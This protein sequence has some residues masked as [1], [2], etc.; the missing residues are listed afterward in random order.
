[1]TAIK[2]IGSNP[3]VGAEQVQAMPGTADRTLVFEYLS[4][5]VLGPYD[6][7]T[8]LVHDQ[9]FRR[10]LMGTLYPA[11]AATEEVLQNE[12]EEASGGS[13]GEE[14]ADDPVTMANSW[15]PS[16][17]GLSFYVG[18]A[19][20]IECKVWGARY[21]SER[22]GRREAFRR[23]PIASMEEPESITLLKPGEEDGGRRT[24]ADVFGG[25]A[26][27]D[28]FWRPLETGHLVTV[29]LRNTQE[30][31]DPAVVDAAK[32]LHQVGLECRPI[33]GV[34]REYP[35]VEFLSP[36]KEEQELR[37]LHRR[38]RVFAI[39]HG[40]AA[41][42][43]ASG[44][45][46]TAVRT[47]LL[48]RHEVPAVTAGGIKDDV[49]L[50]IAYLSDSSVQTDHLLQSLRDFCSHYGAWIEQLPGA[51]ADIPKALSGAR[52]RLVKRLD[53]ALAR[54]RRGVDTLERNP[55]ALRA[56]RLANRAMLMQM[57]HASDAAAGSRRSREAA[58]SA[59]P[60]YLSL[61]YKWRPFQLAFMLLTL[62]SVV[63]RDDTERDT[64]DLLW[65]PT[66]GGKTEAYLAIAALQI[67]MRRL[68]PDKKLDGA[69]TTVITRYTL[70]LLTTQQFQRAATLICACE[71]IRRQFDDE[72]GKIPISIGLW[73]GDTVVPNKYAKAS[74]QFSNLLEDAN[75]ICPFQLE[76]CPWCG[77]EMVPQ[78]RDEDIGAY[79]IR[80]SNASFA[81]FCPAAA[82]AFHARLP[83]GV[84][85]EELFDNPP[86][87]LLATV[88]KF[89]RLAWEERGGVFF[90]AGGHEPPSLVIQD[91]MHLLSGPIGTT[92]GLYE[93]AIE[94]LATYHG[95]R[96]KIIASTATIRRADE[97]VKGL[98]GRE[99]ELF[100]P[101]GLSADDSYFARVDTSRPGRLYVGLM[102]QSHTPHTTIV[103]TAAALLQA[104]IE[105]G[106][107]G[108]N[109]D[110][111]WTLVA[112]H[113]SLRELGRT[114][115]LSRDDIP[116]RLKVIA[117]ADDAQR[118]IPD[119]GVVELTSN[120]SGFALPSLLSRA[121]Q[122]ATNPND[123][124]AIAVLATTNMLSVGVDIQR[125]GLMVMNGQPKTTSE[126]I[127]A[128]SR[129]GRGSVPGLVITMYVSTKPRDRSH[130]ES[131]IPYHAALYKHVEPTS[132]TPFSAPSRERA[133]HAALVI[134]IR[135]G[136]GLSANDSAGQINP[137]SP[138]IM[139]AIETLASRAERVD[140]RE[141]GATRMQLHRRID[142]W[143]RLAIQQQ[144]AGR[145]LYYQASRPHTALLRN[146]GTGGAGWATLHSMRN[147]D[148]QCSVSVMGE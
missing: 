2:E 125:L 91:E 18:G 129:V 6:G 53:S 102:S 143:V 11:N 65:F 34:V 100:P 50:S 87:F 74:E 14:I 56:F 105:L 69:G 43:D 5:Q 113:N 142:E 76:Q 112:Y 61:Q 72:M 126:Y 114:I 133:L 110:A 60:D 24:H 103:H 63:D 25:S 58:T 13:I 44:P 141:A 94:A 36:D 123:T 31:S 137:E 127:Q 117:S 122:R 37:L 116:A 139:R 111:Y 84:I 42:A 77:T 21:T 80:A 67:F 62:P 8:E 64:V 124:E 3:P 51:N 82:C 38:A 121:K 118:I 15:M 20:A 79:G 86:T 41:S 93:G 81:F 108:S 97:Q 140:P 119:N 132:V 55:K 1:L 106:F 71:M 98:F 26:R 28:S 109:I 95:A 40:C 89:A 59:I 47:E 107:A 75:P 52:S 96:P 136:A 35:S 4:R 66:G 7:P 78:R 12:V 49:S 146:F 17:I 9:P 23:Q 92:V 104:P 32:C 46:A 19:D 134:L 57:W 85:D 27:V 101:A 148:R 70:R 45:A 115:T 68:A 147:V 39:G 144:A 130:Y 33:N 83:I 99:V 16:S 88:D 131:F 145:K 29:T 30:Q 48:P 120:V 90:G 22:T 135:H 138:E 128:T 54:I 73:V 10:Y